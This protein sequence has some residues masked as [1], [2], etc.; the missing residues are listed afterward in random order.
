MLEHLN[1]R[2]TPP[3]RVV[4]MGAGGFV[5]GAVAERLGGD[6]IAVLALGRLGARGAIPGIEALLND[7]TEITIY[8]EIMP[9][10]AMISEL[11]ADALAR[12][13]DAEQCYP[14][15]HFD[16]TKASKN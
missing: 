6:G 8:E 7:N 12:I 5:G 15:P 2:P 11:A 3:K 10:T 13:R 14:C 9:R 16:D 4:I 1:E